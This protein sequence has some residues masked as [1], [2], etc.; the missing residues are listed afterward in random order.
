MIE[1]HLL[2]KSTFIRSVQCLK[3]LYLHKNRT[4]LR[5]RLSAE[6]L[7]KFRRGTNVGIL[8]QQLFPGGINLQ[9]KSPSQYRKAI[10]ATTEQILSPDDFIIYEASFQS[11][12]IL[13]ILDVFEKKDGKFYAYEVKSSKGI[14]QTYLYDAA[15]QYYVITKAGIDLEDISIVYVNKNYTLGDELVLSEFFV[16]KSVLEE[17][18]QLQSYISNH[19]P[20]AKEALNLKHS[21]EIEIGKQCHDPYPCDFRGHCWKHYK[22]NEVFNLPFLTADQKFKFK[23]EGL[24]EFK[25]LQDNP[26]LSKIQINKF[27]AHLEEE[28]YI[29][30]IELDKLFKDIKSPYF[31]NFETVAYAVP[32]WKGNTPY[33]QI[34]YQFSLIQ[35]Q[36]DEIIENQFLIKPTSINPIEEVSSV[37]VNALDNIGTLILW[38]QM[39]LFDEGKNFVNNIFEKY[40]II[41][42]YDLFLNDYFYHPLLTNDISLKVINTQLLKNKNDEALMSDLTSIHKFEDYSLNKDDETK[43]IIANDINKS[44]LT[45]ANIIEQ[46]FLYLQGLASGKNCG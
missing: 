5:D 34:V 32:K 38:K 31:L 36:N 46:L 26:S 7:A 10:A 35:V 44:S 1:K 12:Q 20:K 41:D 4:F 19:I 8:A 33:E 30:N 42:L 29:N 24:Y 11:D 6:Q 16:I 17:V 14:S 37:L 39:Y 23:D 43:A 28:P 22:S 21:P 3:S 2:S 13:I 25:Q 18:K 45:K 27:K 9:P 15:L 40:Q